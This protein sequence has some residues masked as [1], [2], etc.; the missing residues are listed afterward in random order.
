MEMEKEMEMDTRSEGDQ[1]SER[2]QAE[3]DWKEG[4]T[5][6]IREAG[7]KKFRELM[8]KRYADAAPTEVIQ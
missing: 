2:N 4:S 5:L 3:R 7:L 6:A 1:D 8:Q